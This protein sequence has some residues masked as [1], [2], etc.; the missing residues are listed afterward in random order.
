VKVRSP[1]I[2]IDQ[3]H[4]SA[5]RLRDAVG[6]GDDENDENESPEAK[7]SCNKGSPKEGP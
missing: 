7:K 1:R 2:G 4:F 5:H 3:F 6:N